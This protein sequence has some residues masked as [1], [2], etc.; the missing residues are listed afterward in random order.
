MLWLVRFAYLQKH[1]F[2]TME[3]RHL[4]YLVVVAEEGHVTRAAERLEIQ[5]PPLSRLIQRVESLRKQTESLQRGER[6]MCPRKDSCAAAKHN[7]IP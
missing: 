3:L 1:G 5:Q 2:L 7:P 4:R 6:R